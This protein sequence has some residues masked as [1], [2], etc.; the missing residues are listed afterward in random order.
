MSKKPAKQP[1]KKPPKE[2]APERSPFRQRT[3]VVIAVCGSISF[4]GWILVGIFANDL[5]DMS[6]TQNDTFS[7]AAVGHHALRSLLTELEIPNEVRRNP[8]QRPGENDLL[9]IAEP[10]LDEDNDVELFEF[11]DLVESSANTLIVLPKRR[12]RPSLTDRNLN[13]SV[14]LLY[15]DE[16]TVCLDA[17]GVDAQADSFA[18]PVDGWRVRTDDMTLIEPTLE[19]T[20]LL[21][22]ESDVNP[23]IACDDGVLVGIISSGE[24][25]RGRCW[26]LSDPDLL[27]N[28]G[29]HRDDNA[30]FSVELITSLLEPDGTVIFDEVYHGH[31]LTPSVFRGLFQ[32]PLGYLTAHGLLA[33]ALMLWA[34]TG[35]YGSPA[36]VSQSYAAGKEPLMRNTAAL[37]AYGGHGAFAIQR[38]LTDTIALVANRL[39]VQ[40]ALEDPQLASTLD[41]MKRS[42]IQLRDLKVEVRVLL[43]GS[44]RMTSRRSARVTTLAREI[45]RWRTEMLDVT[46]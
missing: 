28:H 43:E 42:E 23:V 12:G 32:L 15:G 25:E 46:R 26:V 7:S 41:A 14:R 45:H 5:A 35:R 17:I 2:A 4:L 27:A 20:Q 6:S 37:L 8:R 29:L 13:R 1:A 34:G 24:H 40:L 36:P 19:D 39:H 31:G 21:F 11:R 33:L 10:R 44:R 30:Q 16:N 9:V 3:A 22:E 18:D 38:Y